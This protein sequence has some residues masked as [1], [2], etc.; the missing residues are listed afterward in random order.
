LWPRTTVSES[1]LTSVVNELRL[2]LGDEARKPRF[3]RTVYGFGYAFRGEVGETSE[4]E[5]AAADGARPR[6]VAGSWQRLPAYAA[7]L[8]LAALAAWAGYRRGRDEAMDPPPRFKQ[9]TFRRGVVAEARF[10]P[11]G[12]TVVY[13]AAWEGQH[14]RIY[15][16]RVDSP[17]SRPLDVPEGDVHAVSA[18]GEMAM[19]IGRFYFRKLPQRLARVSMAGGAPR[20]LLEDVVAA[21]WAPNGRDLAVVR[22]DGAGSRLEFPIGKVLYRSHKSDMGFPRVSP[23]GDRVAFVQFRPYAVSVEVVDLEGTRTTLS[24]RHATFGLAWAPDGDEVWFTEWGG[25]YAVR[26]DGRERLLARFPGA[27]T[28]NDVFRDKRALV[29]LA[30]WQSALMVRSP[31]ASEERDLS[32]FDASRVAELGPDGRTLLFSDRASAASIQNSGRALAAYLRPL[33]GS[34]AVRLGDGIALGLSQ[35][36]RWALTQA[37]GPPPRLT[38]LPTGPGEPRGIELGDLALVGNA[39]L[40]PGADS[41]LVT[42]ARPGEGIRVF[43]QDLAGRRRRALTPEGYG[44]LTPVSPDGRHAIVC[45]AGSAP[46]LL[47]VADGSLRPLPGAQQREGPAFWS[48][49]GRFVYLSNRV[50]E[51]PARLSRVELATGRRERWKE[52]MPGD[53][54]A[55]GGFTGMSFTPD[56][57]SYAYSFHR[58]LCALYLVEGLS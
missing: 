57:S 12:Q 8:C 17:E 26:L 32:W 55:F 45:S 54:T 31:G 2:A 11:D 27:V 23:R 21:D 7:L 4:G 1:N 47:S 38:L 18:T 35:D 49:D 5:D 46:V 14:N 44:L 43:A 40:G 16:A 53:A 3:I 42:G 50:D 41:V 6:A 25:L 22:S 33:D 19:S 15:S 56:G 13:G 52:L 28:L 34:A 37:M 29:T 39:A 48:P 9:L 20:A 36:G 10:A 51:I 58:F 30:Q 24:D